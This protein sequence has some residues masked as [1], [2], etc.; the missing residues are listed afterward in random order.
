MNRKHPVALAHFTGTTM[1]LKRVEQTA[2]FA[3]DTRIH[4]VVRRAGYRA[5]HIQSETARGKIDFNASWLDGEPVPGIDTL[6]QD[7]AI[8]LL[9]CLDTASRRLLLSGALG[10]IEQSPL[11]CKTMCGACFGC[12]ALKSA[13]RIAAESYAND[14][15]LRGMRELSDAPMKTCFDVLFSPE[16]TAELLA[17]ASTARGTPAAF[18]G[19]ANGLTDQPKHE[20][21]FAHFDFDVAVIRNGDIIASLGLVYAR[22]LL[23]KLMSIPLPCRETRT[24]ENE[25]PP[26][27]RCTRC[28]SACRTEGACLDCTGAACKAVAIAV[29][30]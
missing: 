17:I 24:L 4:V 12:V 14:G 20:H 1:R 18:A 15:F 27:E 10:S 23:L 9:R 21:A 16:K 5:A 6:P 28:G 29:G 3:D 8:E 7:V 26:I 22:E 11:R 13:L 2:E 25:H 19:H 30:W